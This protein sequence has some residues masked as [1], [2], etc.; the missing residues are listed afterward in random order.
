MFVTH[1]KNHRKLAVVLGHSIY[2]NTSLNMPYMTLF[3][4]ELAGFSSHFL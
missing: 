3:K 2:L 4:T 1:L